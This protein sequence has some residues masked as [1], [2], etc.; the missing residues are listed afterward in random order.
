MCFPLCFPCFNAFIIFSSIKLVKYIIFKEELP[1]QTRNTEISRWLFARERQRFEILSTQVKHILENTDCQAH[2]H[3]LRNFKVRF[4][5]RKRELA[6]KMKFETTA[7]SLPSPTQLAEQTEFQQDSTPSLHTWLP[8]P[9]EL[10][11][12]KAVPET[13]FIH[14]I[15]LQATNK[16]FYYL[17]EI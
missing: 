4:T 13:V 17:K 16:F 7:L 12:Q 1:C 8:H 5:L 11:R 9:A 2:N 3:K 10:T 14:N 6:P 15:R